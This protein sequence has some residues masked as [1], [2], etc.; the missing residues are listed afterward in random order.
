MGRTDSWLFVTPEKSS[1]WG[2]QLLDSR[3]TFK[4]LFLQMKMRQAEG[5]CPSRGDLVGHRVASVFC[6]LGRRVMMA[7]A[8]VK[9]LIRG[10]RVWGVGS[11]KVMSPL[12]LTLGQPR[13]GPL[14]ALLTL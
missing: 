12:F 1:L 6:A 14:C 5:P 4:V 13:T 2:S 11:V 9:F 7:F 3:G 10:S 8:K